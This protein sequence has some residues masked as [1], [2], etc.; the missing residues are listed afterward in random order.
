MC[1]FFCCGEVIDSRLER[2]ASERALDE[3]LVKRSLMFHALH[4]SMELPL[5]REEVFGFFADAGNLQRITPP[6]LSFEILTPLPI[7]MGVGTVITYRLRLLG[8]P[9]R[10]KTLI[11]RWEP[12]G[13]L[14]MNRS[15][16]R[17]FCG[18]TPTVF[19]KNVVGRSF[20]TTFST[21]SP[22]PF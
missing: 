15:R 12:P 9:F 3:P 19:R 1:G 21:V 18:V 16:G 11:S 22:Y 13:F 4:T 5:P 7:A 8:V 20:T 17:M 2:G 14:S 6:E 10:W